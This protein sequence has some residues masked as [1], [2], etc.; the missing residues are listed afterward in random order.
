MD[1]PESLWPCIHRW[2]WDKNNFPHVRL[3]SHA[4][5]KFGEENASKLSPRTV[6]GPE[7]WHAKWNGC[8]AVSFD[9]VGSRV[10]DRDIQALLHLPNLTDL[11]LRRPVNISPAVLK[12]LS[13]RL[14]VVQIN[15]LMGA[16]PRGGAPAFYDAVGSLQ[17]L[18]TLRLQLLDSP[19]LS[20]LPCL[21]AM[22]ILDLTGSRPLK[23][24]DLAWVASLAHLESLDLSKCGLV[25]SLS[26]LCSL[27]ELKALDL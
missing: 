2:L 4:W 16:Y 18:T 27:A 5:A 9:R 20:A 23:M 24:T 21:S 22:R 6:P 3:V 13:E 8:R 11:S 12:M 26:F 1:I 7:G 17:F 19:D 15:M 10:Q 25:S 14:R